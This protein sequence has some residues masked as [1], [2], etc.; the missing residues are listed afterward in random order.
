VITVARAR[1]R[2][3]VAV[4]LAGL[5][6]SVPAA[7]AGQLPGVAPAPGQPA[8]VED[9]E[10]LGNRVAPVLVGGEPT[11]WVPGVGP[12]TPQF[13]ADRIGQ[14]LHEVIRDRSIRDP[15]V[16]VTENEGSSEL[17]VGSRLLMVIT[18]SDARSLGASRPVVAEQ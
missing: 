5:C 13:R 16:T 4:L 15:T 8:P 9:P 12:Y 2:V 1:G 10:A 17:R 6:Y 18:Q 7:L 11:I 14:R 3:V